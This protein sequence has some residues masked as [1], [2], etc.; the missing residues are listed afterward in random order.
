M[1][2]EATKFNTIGLLRDEVTH[3]LGNRTHRKCFLGKRELGPHTKRKQ[4]D[5]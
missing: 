5:C 2:K 4:R 1:L 3:I